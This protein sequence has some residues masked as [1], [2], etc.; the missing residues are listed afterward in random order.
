MTLWMMLEL[1][2]PGLPVDDFAKADGFTD[3]DEMLDWFE[4]VHGLPFH[5]VCIR[6]EI[7]G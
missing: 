3:A 4:E 2:P 6:F 1:P 7:F 5:G